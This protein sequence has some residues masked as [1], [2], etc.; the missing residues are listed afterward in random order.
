MII[1]ASSGSKC[2]IFTSSFRPGSSSFKTFLLG[3]ISK[4]LYGPSKKGS[5]FVLL[6]FILYTLVPILKLNL[7]IHFLFSLMLS[8]MLFVKYGM[9]FMFIG[10]DFCKGSNGF[11][12]NRI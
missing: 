11:V 7:E 9:V 12:L 10:L 5:H 1:W 3:K 8:L 2:L 6:S 4:I